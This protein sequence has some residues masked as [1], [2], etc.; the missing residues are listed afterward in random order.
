MLSEQ[1]IS[2]LKKNSDF[3]EF[4]LWMIEMIEGL[5][6]VSG[7]GSMTIEQ[8]GEEAQTRDRVKN[9]LYDLLNPFIAEVREKRKPTPEEIKKAELKAGIV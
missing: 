2:N 5:D 6:T 7:L 9:R 1:V 8:A 4:Q 3:G